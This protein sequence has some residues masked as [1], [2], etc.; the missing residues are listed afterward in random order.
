M[1]AHSEVYLILTVLRLVIPRCNVDTSFVPAPAPA[2]ASPL[3]VAALSTNLG[4]KSGNIVNTL[5]IVNSEHSEHSTNLPINLHQ[6]MNKTWARVGVLH[7]HSPTHCLFANQK[8][9]SRS[10]QQSPDTERRRI[11]SNSADDVDDDGPEDM[12]EI[13]S[14]HITLMGTRH[15]FSN[16]SGWNL[17]FVGGLPFDHSLI[18]CFPHYLQLKYGRHMMGWRPWFW[19][20]CFPRPSV[21][22]HTTFCSHLISIPIMFYG[23]TRLSEFWLWFLLPLTQPWAPQCITA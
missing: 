10:R 16:M 15:P 23:Q 4:T 8:K 18:P 11:Q 7:T 20:I 13:I 19:R 3:L 6:K 2:A 9:P 5:N 22:F 17:H 12:F 14:H 21:Q 1:W